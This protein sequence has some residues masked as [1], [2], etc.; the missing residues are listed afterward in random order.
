MDN[1]VGYFY[2]IS[3]TDIFHHSFEIRADL[4]YDAKMIQAPYVRKLIYLY[5]IDAMVMRGTY[6]VV[7]RST[8]INIKYYCEHL[9]ICLNILF[10]LD[11]IIYHWNNGCFNQHI[12]VYRLAYALLYITSYYPLDIINTVWPGYQIIALVVA[13]SLAT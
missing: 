8:G 13:I 2:T 7:N 6:G 5:N 9:S 1:V 12:Y 3:H 11:S 10:L 4:N